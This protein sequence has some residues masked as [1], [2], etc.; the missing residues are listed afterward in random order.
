MKKNNKKQQQENKAIE[1]FLTFFWVGKIRMCPGTFGSIAT[2]PFWILINL[3]LVSIGIKNILIFVA[4]WL[5]LITTMFIYGVK[6]SNIYIKKNNKKEDP[7]EIVIDEVVG[8]LLTFLS[9]VV[10][11]SYFMLQ[12]LDILEKQVD[13]GFCKTMSIIMI[14]II[15]IIMF[16]VFD[17][18]KP[19]IIGYCD[20]NFHG[21]LGVMLD[22]LVAGLF[23]S[24]SL[25]LIYFVYYEY[26][27]RYFG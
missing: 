26:V 7:Q 20:K 14:T 25:A 5:I 11:G 1:L 24:I 15:P 18:A 27:I 2:L 12:N 17:I 9:A 13:C 23:A 10:F 16:R 22:D 21:G 4:F 19:W 8:Q 3:I 6:I